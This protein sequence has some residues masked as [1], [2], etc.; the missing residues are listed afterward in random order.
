MAKQSRASSPELEDDKRYRIS[1]SRAVH[2]LGKMYWVPGAP[3][4]AKGRMIR[5]LSGRPE[6]EGAITVGEEVES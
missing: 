1:V 6:N 3:I 4:E 5:E 2:V